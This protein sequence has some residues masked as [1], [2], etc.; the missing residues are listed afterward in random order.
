MRILLLHCAGSLSHEVPH[1]S[2]ALQCLVIMSYR[3]A[4]LPT[5]DM[6]TDVFARAVARAAKCQ[7]E[8]W[9]AILT[10]IIPTLCVNGPTEGFK[11]AASAQVVS[12]I[13]S[14]FKDDRQRFI[15]ALGSMLQQVL[16]LV[17]FAQVTAHHVHTS[18][19]ALCIMQ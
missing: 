3:Q 8:D 14:E 1:S 10:N 18:I 9:L 4:N 5:L 7:Q 13:Q 16:Q 6:Y 15:S 17:N 19:I 12:A 2:V 11:A